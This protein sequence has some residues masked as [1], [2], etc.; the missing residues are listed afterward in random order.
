MEDGRKKSPSGE[1]RIYITEENVCGDSTCKTTTN[2]EAE[3]KREG[4]GFYIE[5]KIER[6]TSHYSV[7]MCIAEER[8]KN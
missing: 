5:K 2:L 3:S 8:K 4:G 7:N 6:T 1:F